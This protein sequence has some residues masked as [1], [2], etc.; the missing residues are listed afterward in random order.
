MERGGLYWI[1]KKG[2]LCFFYV[3]SSDG[4]PEVCSHKTLQKCL[5]RETPSLVLKMKINSLLHEKDKIISA[6]PRVSNGSPLMVFLYVRPIQGRIQDFATGGGPL[7]T[8]GGGF[9]PPKRPPPIHHCYI[10]YC[11]LEWANF[12]VSPG[13]PEWPAVYKPNSQGKI[14]V[15]CCLQTKLTR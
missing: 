5:K 15:T 6:S 4:A 10:K 9:K 14:I 13:R 1:P 7:A 3:C 12:F 11:I 2:G 8:A